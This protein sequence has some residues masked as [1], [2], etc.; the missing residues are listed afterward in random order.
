MHPDS[1]IPDRKF[2]LDL[3]QLEHADE[4][5]ILLG[6]EEELGPD[7]FGPDEKLLPP[8]I[9]RHKMEAKRTSAHGDVDSRVHW[10]SYVAL[11]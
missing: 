11:N 7:A 3:A 5:A 6:A 9:L 8:W 2:F 10:F 4:D 1:S